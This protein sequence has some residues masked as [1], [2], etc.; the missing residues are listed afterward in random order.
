MCLVLDLVS[1]DLF[2]QILNG[3]NTHDLVVTL[4]GHQVATS[5]DKFAEQGVQSGHAADD[6]GSVKWQLAERSWL[7]VKIFVD[8]VF[9]HQDAVTGSKLFVKHR[10][11]APA[12]GFDLIDK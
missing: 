12:F 9:H 4:H 10:N 8:K 11:P 2:Y 3:H 1:Q 5:R 6:L 7:R